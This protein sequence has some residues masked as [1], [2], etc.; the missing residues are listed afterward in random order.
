MS[1][2]PLTLVAEPE[3]DAVA[4]DAGREP[5]TGLIGLVMLARFHNIAAD[6][7][8]LAHDFREA[9][10]DFGVPQILLAARQLGLKAKLVRTELSRL[11]Q[12]PLP[13]L[14]VGRDGRFVILARADGDGDKLLIHDPLV[15][16]PQVLSAAEFEALER[17]T[18]PVRLAGRRTGEV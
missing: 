3:G 16:R 7:D 14:A 4:T 10:Q 12:T 11:A 13:A 9:G 8:Q 15:E 17:R 18:D 2:P 6:A 5:D 1:D